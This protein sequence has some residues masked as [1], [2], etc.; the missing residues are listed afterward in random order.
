M[1]I[2]VKPAHIICL[3]GLL[4]FAMNVNAEV[5]DSSAPPISVSQ[6]SL[7]DQKIYD[8]AS[9]LIHKYN[10]KGNMLETAYKML[11]DLVKRNPKSGYPYAALAEL[12][13]RLVGMGDGTYSDA[14]LLAKKAIQLDPNI[15][16]AYAV[17]AK[18]LIGLNNINAARDAANK[19][20]SLDRND[21]GAMFAMARVAEASDQYDEAERWYRKAIDTFKDDIRRSNL[22]FWLGRM[23]SNKTPMDVNAVVEAY[24]KSAELDFDNGP[25]KL[26]SIGNFLVNNTDRYDQA[27]GYLEQAIKIS[28]PGANLT[29]LGLAE[30]YKWG[31]SIQNPGKYKDDKEKPLNPETITAATGVTPEYAFVENA[32]VATEPS[33]SIALLNKGTIKNVDVVPVGSSTALILAAYANHL[34]L[35]KLLIAKG[36]NVNAET[37]DTKTTSLGYAVSENNAD[38]VKLLVENGARLNHV[39][40]TGSPIVSFAL[41]QKVG[42]PASILSYLLEHGADPTIPDK[43]GII[44]IVNAVLGNDVEAVRLLVNKYH[45][46]VNAKYFKMP[47]LEIAAMGNGWP[48]YASDTKSREIV[49]ILLKAGANP[50]IKDSKSEDLVMTMLGPMV[51]PRI[52]PSYKEKAFMIIEARKST[53]KPQDFGRAYQSSK[54]YDF[55]ESSR[56]IAR[57]AFLNDA[58]AVRLLVNK[59]H[60]NVNAKFYETPILAVAAAGAGTASKEIVQ[61]LLEAGANP[62][63]WDGDA[64]LVDKLLVSRYDPSKYPSI[65]ENTAMIID[66]RKHFPKPANFGPGY[67][68]R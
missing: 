55:N 39:N 20:I 7:E 68:G 58:A 11:V 14:Y 45:A 21:P 28:G 31:N 46:D 24:T 35:V 53:P 16:D 49:D 25:W 19:A 18:I 13:Y 44:L 15:V 66:A 8:E 40:N 27:I 5:I 62:W 47:I 36:A 32:G 34:D 54:P 56:A 61:I 9:G 3:C 48:A 30:Y 50:W 6:L 29:A 37:K 4:S 63:I 43:N 1:N 59:S 42:K 67:Q 52:F 26:N 10:G 22:Y 64:D 12:K 23:L 38:M 2:L 41:N 60:A 65:K 33:A 51:D 17:E 57:A